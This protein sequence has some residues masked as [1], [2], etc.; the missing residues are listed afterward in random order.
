[1]AKHPAS[2]C[3]RI[4]A[5]TTRLP[6][7]SPSPQTGNF[8]ARSRGFGIRCARFTDMSPS[9]MQGSLPVDG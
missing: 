9:P 5:P 6:P 4:A 8:A 3:N 7:P 2:E 1:L